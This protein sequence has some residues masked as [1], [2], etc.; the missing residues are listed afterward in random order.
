VTFEAGGDGRTQ[1]T[2]TEYGY[3]SDRKAG[4]SRAGMEQCLDKMAA[5]FAK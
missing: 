3:S 1:M 5:I 2:V 4:L